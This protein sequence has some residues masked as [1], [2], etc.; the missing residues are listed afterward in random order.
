MNYLHVNLFIEL[1][2]VGC[3]LAYA[4]YISPGPRDLRGE[5]GQTVT[6]PCQAH[7]EPEPQ[8][9]WQHD[10]NTLRHDDVHY[11]Q[12]HHDLVIQGLSAQDAGHYVCTANNG[13][14]P[15]AESHIHLNIECKLSR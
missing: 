9:F 11:V 15:S 13:I 5:P 2:C 7:G 8:V 12:R 14:G 6:L 4:A 1:I 10:N 3:S